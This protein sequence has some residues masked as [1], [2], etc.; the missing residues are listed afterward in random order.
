LWKF[1]LI[2]PL[3]ISLWLWILTTLIFIVLITVFLKEKSVNKTKVF[4]KYS[5]KISAIIIFIISSYLLFKVL[6]I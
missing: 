5:S 6:S 1:T 3:I 2:V 4:S